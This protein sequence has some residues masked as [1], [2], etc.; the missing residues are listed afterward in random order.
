MSPTSN[1]MAS[2]TVNQHVVY[3]VHDSQSALPHLNASRPLYP[4][5]TNRSFSALAASGPAIFYHPNLPLSSSTPIGPL[6]H[7]QQWNHFQQQVQQAEQASSSYALTRNELT[8]DE[9]SALDGAEARGAR[10]RMNKTLKARQRNKT[11]RRGAGP[12][13]F[14]TYASASDNLPSGITT[15]DIFRLYPNHITEHEVEKLWRRGFSA[16]KISDLMPPETRDK[17]KQPWSMYQKMFRKL[18]ER[19]GPRELLEAEIPRHQEDQEKFPNTQRRQSLSQH[20]PEGES[21]TYIADLETTNVARQLLNSNCH[22]LPIDSGMTHEAYQ[23]SQSYG[24]LRTSSE[25]VDE[26]I[27]PYES[28]RIGT[29]D[30]DLSYIVH[31]AAAP[32]FPPAHFRQGERSA[33]APATGHVRPTPMM[34][35]TLLQGSRRQ[36]APPPTPHLPVMLPSGRFRTSSTLLDPTRAPFVPSFRELPHSVRHQ[37]TQ[38][39]GPETATQSNMQEE[40]HNYSPI[41]FPAWRTTTAPPMPSPRVVSEMRVNLEPSGLSTPGEE[42]S[43]CIFYAA[44]HH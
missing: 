16:R 17:C 41:A 2:P 29:A 44:K 8:S 28:G 33:G 21:S 13:R 14:P 43:F 25:V 11:V 27:M 22:G 34:S 38:T 15:E 20:A 32:R 23:A 36:P 19:F 24:V 12:T 10:R 30:Q 5:P 18:K 9:V 1:I 35:S 4:T 6:I 31:N 7:P 42:L 3:D 39:T 40:N 37:V 26:S